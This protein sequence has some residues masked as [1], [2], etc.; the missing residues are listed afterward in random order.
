MNA[1]DVDRSNTRFALLAYAKYVDILIKLNEY[2]DKIDLLSL[3]DDLTSE[4][5]KVK[6]TT[7]AL[8]KARRL[9]QEES[10]D[11]R[12]KIVVIFTNGFSTGRRIIPPET[13]S[14]LLKSFFN[15]VVSI[16][17]NHFRPP[18]LN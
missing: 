9:L 16:V 3:I 4:I 15:K 5:F 1:F 8:Y 13:V 2:N 11:G 14:I 12:K 10:T 17:W 18:N 6:H 7:L